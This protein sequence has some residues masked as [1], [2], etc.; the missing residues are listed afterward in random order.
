MSR[1]YVLKP[2]TQAERERAL[3]VGVVLQPEPADQEEKQIL[4]DI[5]A[6]HYV[7]L[8]RKEIRDLVSPG[9]THRE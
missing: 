4:A 3:E 7:S 9:Q 1:V 6:G 5:A 8:K 2:A